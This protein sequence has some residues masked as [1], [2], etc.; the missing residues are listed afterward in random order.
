MFLFICNHPF[1]VLVLFLILLCAV[2]FPVVCYPYVLSLRNNFTV[3]VVAFPVFVTLA[4]LSS[5]KL[6]SVSCRFPSL[7]H[8][9]ILSLRNN[10]TVCIFC[11]RWV[12][13]TV[14]TS[15][16]ISCQE[17]LLVTQLSKDRACLLPPK[18]RTSP[19]IAISTLRCNDGNPTGCLYLSDRQFMSPAPSHSTSS[20]RRTG[21]SAYHPHI[22]CARAPLTSPSLHCK[23]LY[24]RSSFRSKQTY[25]GRIKCVLVFPTSRYEA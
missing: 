6:Y 18:T 25:T 12:F 23:H 7:C 9:C 15:P 20:I 11:W 2:A 13:M 5:A 1:H 3:Y 19:C 10:F 4:F 24:S 14:C 17:P 21:H 16:F 8:P 22:Q